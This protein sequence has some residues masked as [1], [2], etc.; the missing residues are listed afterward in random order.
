MQ[1]EKKLKEKIERLRQKMI[2]DGMN[3]GLEDKETLVYSQELDELIYE[4]QMKM[5]AG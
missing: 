2:E 1:Y 3:K 4:Y 5:M